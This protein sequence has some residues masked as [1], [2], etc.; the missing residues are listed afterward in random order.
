[1]ARLN[2]SFA[3]GLGLLISALVWAPTPARAVD[4]IFC[5]AGEITLRS[6]RL[7]LVLKGVGDSRLRTRRHEFVVPAGAAIDP[8][9]EAV[10]YYV[11][12]DHQPLYRAELPAGALVANGSSLV[13]KQQA[14]GGEIG[15]GSL[16]KLQQSGN[17]FKMKARWFGATA[18]RPFP[19]A[20]SGSAPPH[21]DPD[22][23]VRAGAVR[24][25]A[26][27][28]AAGATDTGLRVLA[29][30]ETL[31]ARVTFTPVASRQTQPPSTM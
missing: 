29:P 12:A 28:V 25:G 13:F 24:A 15:K 26:G 23:A 1:M 5:P 2:P 31:E 10:T 7:T 17:L 4:P 3:G 14:G 22:R 19:C 6:D 11:E 21:P 9:N 16:L 27:L 8:G 30:R 20:E 18:Q